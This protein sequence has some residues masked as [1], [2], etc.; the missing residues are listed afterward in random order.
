MT[1]K[2]ALMWVGI[3]VGLALLF[4]AG[5]YLWAG[6]EKALQF[7]G[8]YIIEQTLSMDNLFLFLLI[9]SS[10]TIPPVYQRRVLNYGIMGAVVLRLIFILLGVAVVNRFHWVLYI[11]GALLLISGYKMFFHSDEARD[12][13]DSFLLKTLGKLIPLTPHLVDQKFFVR[14]GKLLYA[15]PLL[16]VLVLVEGSDIV[17]AIDSIPAIFSITRDPFIVFTSNMFAIMG[18]RSM[19]FVLEKL[20]SAFRFV[21]Y[22]VALILIFTGIKLTILMFHIEIPLVLSIIVIFAILGLSIA[23]SALRPEKNLEAE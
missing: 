19:Y 3:W 23:I 17:F 16:A 4:N 21:K 9:F 5:I 15:T 12:F 22:G 18:L 10:F 20:H 11:F 13:K 6:Q 2:K 14:K 8:G 7:F 1:V